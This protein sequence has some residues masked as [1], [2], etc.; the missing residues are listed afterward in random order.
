MKVMPNLKYTNSD[1]WVSVDGKI[2]TLGISDYAQSQ[3]SDIVFVEVIAA[4]GDTIAKS[5]TV[6]TVESVKA[7]ADV[8]S[9]VAGK[10]VEINEALSGTPEQVNSDPFGAAWLIK[11]ELSSPADLDNL[12]DAQAYEKYCA[13]RSH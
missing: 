4:I 6:A 10:V 8:I 9:P 1:E 2:A 13:S 3:L 5:D 12:M 11:V 7:S